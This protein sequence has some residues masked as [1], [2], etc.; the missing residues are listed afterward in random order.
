MRSDFVIVASLFVGCGDF[1]FRY[2]YRVG[3]DGVRVLF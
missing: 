2:F 1:F 3:R